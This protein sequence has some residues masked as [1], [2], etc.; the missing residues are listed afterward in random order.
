M[1]KRAT[2]NAKRQ[3]AECCFMRY[4]VGLSLRRITNF[5]KNSGIKQMQIWRVWVYQFSEKL[6][7]DKMDG[8]DRE[9]LTS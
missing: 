4:T 2:G 3:Q 5:L 8:I 9:E 1:Q 6:K 7:C